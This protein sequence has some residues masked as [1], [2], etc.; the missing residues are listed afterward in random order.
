MHMCSTHQLHGH[1]GG[2]YSRTALTQ[3]S[4]EPANNMAHTLCL[5][6]GPFN[7]GLVQ[8]CRCWGW[9]DEAAIPQQYPTHSTA[10]MD[11]GAKGTL[12]AQ[13]TKQSPRQATSRTCNTHAPPVVPPPPHACRL[14]GGR[15]GKDSTRCF[16]LAANPTAAGWWSGRLDST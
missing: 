10:T 1:A 8:A 11:T 16:R 9:W 7:G 12:R 4:A 14:C 5:P 6:P 13:Y 15:Q 3:Q 2:E